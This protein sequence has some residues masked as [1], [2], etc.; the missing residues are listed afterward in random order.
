MSTKVTRRRCPL[1]GTKRRPFRDR[2]GCRPAISQQA[3]AAS[4]MLDLKLAVA[5]PDINPVTNSALK[6]AEIARLLRE[7]RCP[8]RDRAARRHAAGR[9]RAECRPCGPRRP[10]HRCHAAAEGRQRR[11]GARRRVGDARSAL[12]DRGQVR[13]HQGRG[14]VGR[15]YAIADN[16]SLDHNL[17]QHVLG[18]LRACERDG[19]RIRHDRPA[20]D[21]RAGARRRAGRRDDGVVRHL[22]ADRRHAGTAASSS[23]PRTSSPPRRS[24][25]SSS[26]RSSR[27]SPR[28]AKPSS[29]SS[30]RWSTS[31][32]SIDAD[33]GAWVQ[34]MAQGARGPEPGEPAGDHQVPRRPLVR[35]RLPQ[36]R[37]HPGYGG[38]HLREPG[39]RRRAGR[40]RRRR[41][42]RERSSTARSRSSAPT[43]AAA[44]TPGPKVRRRRDAG[45]QQSHGDHRH[46]LD[47]V[48]AVSRS[49]GA[50]PRHRG[51]PE[52]DRR[53]RAA[54]SARS[55]AS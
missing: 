53:R 13:D 36:R 45:D 15:T 10:Q 34:A 52:G 40:H 23:S 35:E 29:G 50:R 49:L 55:T 16:G 5:D 41:D 8:G 22:P 51:E 2:A 42:R 31:P 14:L 25:R 17:T 44:S 12:P 26:R 9:R 3:P 33:A 21:P 38:L 7:A 1:G 47:R 24:S 32:G 4:E 27:R 43:R 39:L 54:A 11:S 20:G 48:H 19:P 28:R 18:E 6:L 37:L 46:R 30:T